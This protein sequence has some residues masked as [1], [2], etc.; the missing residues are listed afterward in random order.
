MS[1]ASDTYK[2]QFALLLSQFKSGYPAYK[3]EKQRNIATEA[4]S[5]FLN[6][7]RNL[8]NLFKDM[9]L[10]EAEND[11]KIRKINNQ[12]KKYDSEISLYKKELKRE[13]QKLDAIIQRSRAGEQFKEQYDAVKE[14][15]TNS[16]YFDAFSVVGAA[17][18]TYLIAMA[19]QQV[20]SHH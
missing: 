6:V 11:A 7:E 15:T 19:G 5:N 3:L 4:T 12:L 9:S 2:R 16:L 17:Y 13:K 14:D 8:N 18:L 10:E 1:S 20:M